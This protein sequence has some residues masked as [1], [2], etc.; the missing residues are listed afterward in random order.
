MPI[1]VL[2]LVTRIYRVVIKY[3]YYPLSAYEVMCIFDYYLNSYVI[4][5]N[6]VITIYELK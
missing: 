2:E 5:N 6:A 3:D 1:S 4:L